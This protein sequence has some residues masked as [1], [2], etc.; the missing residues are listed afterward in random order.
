M[1]SCIFYPGHSVLRHRR[2]TV[3]LIR[4]CE[5]L[6]VE[7]Q[8]GSETKF[9]SPLFSHYSRLDPP[10]MR[11]YQVLSI[12]LSSIILR[13]LGEPIAVDVNPRKLALVR[14][15]SFGG[16][17]QR[18]G[19]TFGRA[20][21]GDVYANVNEQANRRHDVRV[22][23]LAAAGA[24]GGTGSGAGYKR[25]GPGAGETTKEPGDGASNYVRSS[26]HLSQLRDV[27]L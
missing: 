15:R 14:E 26:T 20:A 3:S 13:V 5:K 19:K 6:E 10:R 18:V 24:A 7:V 8:K 23:A 27:A 9:L 16:G 25:G 21:P 2:E 11:P 22:N 17:E 12:L 1:R 4:N